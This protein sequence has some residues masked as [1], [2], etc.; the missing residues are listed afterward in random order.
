MLMAFWDAEDI[1]LEIPAG[2]AMVNAE[3]Y[4]IALWHMKE[5]TQMK[6]PILLTEIVIHL[7]DNIS[8]YS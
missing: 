4:H 2:R 8:P 3:Y 5:V 1:L 6:C 7:H